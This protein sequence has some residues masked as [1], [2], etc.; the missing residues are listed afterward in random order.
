MMCRPFTN[1][2]GWFLLQ[3]A[4]LPPSDALEWDGNV[5]R[6]PLAVLL[7]RLRM[8]QWPQGEYFR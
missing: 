7:V 6:V 5:G 1:G 2:V 8:S 3:E 4:G